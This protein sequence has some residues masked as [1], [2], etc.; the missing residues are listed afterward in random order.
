MADHIWHAYVAD[1]DGQVLTD[2][3]NIASL[4]IHD[5]G[6]ISIRRGTAL[7]NRDG[8]LP[9][10]D[11]HERMDLFGE[12][13]LDDIHP[14]NAEQAWQLMQAAVAGMN[15]AN[16]REQ[17]AAVYA[18]GDFTG[19]ETWSRAEAEEIISRDTVESRPVLAR[20]WASDWQRVEAAEG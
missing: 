19:G 10:L 13:D 18:D 20:R 7:P 6:T 11:E 3:A 9:R 5:Q 1:A 8:R 16:L 12:V 2:P 4:L 15:A 14:W 17:W